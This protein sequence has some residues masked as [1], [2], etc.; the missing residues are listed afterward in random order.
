MEV[1][2]FQ[3]ITDR[4]HCDRAKTRTIPRSCQHVK[5]PKRRGYQGKD[6]R[7]KCLQH[8]ARTPL[9]TSAMQTNGESRTHISP[10]FR[11]GTTHTT[12]NHF[13]S[14]TFEKTNY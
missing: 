14:N 13:V 7:G 10:A 3:Y 5:H 11:A 4:P 9:A 8:R 6:A 1:L 2:K 12:T